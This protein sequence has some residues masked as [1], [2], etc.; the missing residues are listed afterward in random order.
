ADTIKRAGDD[1]FT[2]GT[3][4]RHELYLAQ[5]P[6]VFRR[7]WIEQ[8]YAQRGKR[9]AG[10]TDDTQL[11]EG[12]GHRCRI[13]SGSPLNLKIT[14]QVDLRLAGAILRMESNSHRDASGHPFADEQAMWAN[15]PKLKPSDLFDS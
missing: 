11:V 13:V 1:R 7:E 15:L 3:V 2:T 8:A 4:A 5:T 6:Q 9:D 10:S 12:L 14:T